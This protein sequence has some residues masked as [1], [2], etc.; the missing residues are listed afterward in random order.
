MAVPVDQLDAATRARLG[1]PA[2]TG[3]AKPAPTKA[4]SGGWN[5][6]CSSCGYTPP[7]A[8]AAGRHTAEQDHCR[9]HYPTGEVAP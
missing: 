3:R 8:T 5:L 7:G 4:G 2:N 9:W 6:T 1:L